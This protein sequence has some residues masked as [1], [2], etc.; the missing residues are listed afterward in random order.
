ML[1]G[2]QCEFVGCELVGSEL[3]EILV[4]DLV[5]GG[6]RFGQQQGVV[7]RLQLLRRKQ[8]QLLGQ[9]RLLLLGVERCD[10]LWCERCELLRRQCVQLHQIEPDDLFGRQRL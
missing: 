9:Q 7:E 4:Y 10:L 6:F 3:L 8:C 1:W 5:G 2:E